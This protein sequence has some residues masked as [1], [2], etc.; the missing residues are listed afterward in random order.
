MVSGLIQGEKLSIRP[1][2]VVP[3]VCFLPNAGFG[4]GLEEM[5]RKSNSS[6][7]PEISALDL[8][9]IERQ[10][11]S[12]SVAQYARSHKGGVP[13]WAVRAVFRVANQTAG[14]SKAPRAARR[15][16]MSHGASDDE[17]MA[18]LTETQENAMPVNHSSPASP[19][20]ARTKI[21]TD[22]AAA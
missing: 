16:S 22:E 21:F 3:G 1:N 5:S 12:L 18:P 10:A 11:V 17:T 14:A 19:A 9:L 6:A 8:L 4:G 15:H 13:N 2:H 20:S 7:G